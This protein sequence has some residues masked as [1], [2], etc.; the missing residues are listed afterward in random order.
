MKKFRKNIAEISALCILLILWVS[1]AG[2]CGSDV[3]DT[4]D[5]LNAIPPNESAANGDV[6]E[7]TEAM[8]LP[9]GLPVSNM[10]GKEITLGL[11]N[12][13]NYFPLSIQDIEVEEL[14]GEA[15]NDAAF[16]RNIFMEQT[17]NCKINTV[18]FPGNGEALTS[19]RK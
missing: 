3:G 19:L 4:T 15:I 5:T 2:A 17:F 7:E 8:G 9:P 6:P 18:V 13:S 12:W 16:N 14:T 1:I 10:D 11:T